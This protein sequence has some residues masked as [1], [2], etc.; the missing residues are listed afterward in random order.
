MT[1]GNDICRFFIIWWKMMADKLSLLS[2]PSVGFILTKFQSCSFYSL[3]LFLFHIPVLVMKT[4]HNSA[5]YGVVFDIFSDTSI[6]IRKITY[7]S[8]YLSK[9]TILTICISSVGFKIFLWTPKSIWR[10]TF[11][12]FYL[13]QMLLCLL[14]WFNYI[15]VQIRLGLKS[16][17]SQT[18][19]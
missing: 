7:S 9:Q 3:V 8:L 11:L 1:K 15:N 6:L 14:K 12:S 2:H 18:Q 5:V 17:K 10:I 4:N 13:Y 16:D 19:L